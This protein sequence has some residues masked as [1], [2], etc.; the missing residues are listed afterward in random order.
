MCINDNI[1][2]KRI[3]ILKYIIGAKVA[4]TGF[5]V[6]FLITITFAAWTTLGSQV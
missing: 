5:L 1:P 6:L 4:I 2:I 3:I